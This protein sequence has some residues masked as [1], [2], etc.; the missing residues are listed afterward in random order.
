MEIYECNQEVSKDKK[1]ELEDIR[2]YKLMGNMIRARAK[3]VEEGEKPKS[4]FLNLEN[5]H[6]TNKIIPK[7]IKIGSKEIE[8]TDQ[9][10]I[11][12]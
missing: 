7:L 11:L 9:N 10:E 1:K 4:Y 2:S 5:R 12:T 3:S 6:F 8:I